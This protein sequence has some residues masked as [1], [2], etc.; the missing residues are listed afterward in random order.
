VRAAVQWWLRLVL[1]LI[2]DK[3]FTLCACRAVDARAQHFNSNG[4]SF[5]IGAHGQQTVDDAAVHIRLLRSK[6]DRRSLRL[7]AV[8]HGQLGEP[9]TVWDDGLVTIDHVFHSL[10]LR[11]NGG[12]L[13]RN[14]G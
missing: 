10:N 13:Q 1:S 4:W 5:S 6:S 2:D 14:P 11:V 7:S 9:V 3:R 8:G 12:L